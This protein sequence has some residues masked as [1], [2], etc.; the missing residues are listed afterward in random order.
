MAEA[1]LQRKSPMALA[2]QEDLAP[3]EGFWTR[4][5]R[6]FRQHRMA[7]AGSLILVVFALGAIL[8]PQLTSYEPNKQDLDNRLAPPSWEHP[9]GTDE[10]GR[11]LL[12][13][14]LHGGRISM[15]IGVLAMSVAVTVGTLFGAIAGYYGGR[16]DS[17]LMRFTD[18]AISFPSL[19]LLILL[20]AY[21]GSSVP[22]IVLVIGLLSWMRVA[23]L[24]RAS[25]M[26]LKAQQF[27]EAAR[28][29]GVGAR[30]IIIYHLLPN[31][32][33]PIIVAASLGVAGAILTESALSYLGLG[34]Q[35]PTAT[36]GSM[37]RNAQDQMAIAPW[38]AIFPGLMIFLTVIAINYVG[39]GL[40]DALDPRQLE[41]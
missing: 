32:M 17:A 35:P 24:V 30:R 22:T 9:M 10:L 1:S 25:F 15:L 33:G 12:T 13:R 2:M 4:P 20:A 16:I 41:R 34:I 40:R 38:T 37:L 19:F 28:C 11:D 26:S 5:W 31:A 23:R 8:A 29:C 27:V 14:I 18:V 3:A 39:D 21:F 7:L 36:W 6:R